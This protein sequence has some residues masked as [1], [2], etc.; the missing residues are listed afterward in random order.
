MLKFLRKKIERLLS[1]HPKT[2]WAQVAPQRGAF[3]LVVSRIFRT[4]NSVVHW[5]RC[6]FHT[7]FYH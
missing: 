4:F 5:L 6:D 3:V 2:G 7:E 1:L